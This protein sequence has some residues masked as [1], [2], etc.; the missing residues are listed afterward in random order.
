MNSVEMIANQK[1][2]LEDGND[3]TSASLGSPCQAIDSIERQSHSITSALWKTK[4]KSF[5]IMVVGETGLGKTTCLQ[6][7]FHEAAGEIKQLMRNA[8]DNG[9]SILQSTQEIKSYGPITLFGSSGNKLALHIV[10]TPGYMT[11]KEEQQSSQKVFEDAQKYVKDQLEHWYGQEESVDQLP[12][13]ER[14]DARV[15]ACLYFIAPHRMKPIDITYMSYL[16]EYTN[17][18]PI[19]A[20]ADTLTTR[21]QEDQKQEVLNSIA[22][23]KINIFRPL[24][25]EV[26]KLKAITPHS[27]RPSSER[28]RTFPPYAVIGCSDEIEKDGKTV[29]GRQYPYGFAE[30]DNPNH[31]DVQALVSAL[32]SKSHEELRLQT[33]AKYRKYRNEKK[34]AEK[35]ALEK[36]LRAQRGHRCAI[37]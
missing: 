7:I 2:R 20:K 23:G 10:D 36:Q 19:L 3:N 31:C 15:H 27:P 13:E 22:S 11:F 26:G 30:V 4:G 37:S 28:M 29:R 1:Q 21:E 18:V 9:S 25:E 16:Q 34:K 8:S 17:I 24:E 5:K 33:D 35:D 32:L 14:D 6:T 12:V